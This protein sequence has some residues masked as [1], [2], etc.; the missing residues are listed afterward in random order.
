MPLP[1]SGRSL[2]GCQPGLDTALGERYPDIRLP[3]GDSP[4]YLRH[5]HH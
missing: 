4:R 2:P 3:N 5:D 1:P